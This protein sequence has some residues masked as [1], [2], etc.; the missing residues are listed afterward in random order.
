M[1][2]KISNFEKACPAK[3]ERSGGFSLVELLIVITIIGILSTIILSSISNARARA[4]D[5]KV[6]QQLSS[7]RTAAEMY[8]ANQVPNGYGIANDCG[9]GVFNNVDAVNGSPGLYIAPGNLPDFS[10][11]VC[12]STDTAYALKAT[13]YSGNEYWC[14]DSKG[15]SRMVLDGDPATFCP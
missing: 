15:A 4:Y 7:F 2:K 1:I 6:K 8:F 3:L 13:L 14:I 5:S 11:P 10:V 9:T 12:R